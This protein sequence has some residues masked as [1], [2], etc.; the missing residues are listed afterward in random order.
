MFMLPFDIMKALLGM[1]KKFSLDHQN[2]ARRLVPNVHMRSATVYKYQYV[3]KYNQKTP[4][5]YENSGNKT[6]LFLV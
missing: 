4:Y 3:Q 1:S 2:H 5:N 6:I